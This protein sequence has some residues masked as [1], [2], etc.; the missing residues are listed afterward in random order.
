MVDNIHRR[1]NYLPLIPILSNYR[2]DDFGHDLAAGLVVGVITVPQAIAYAFL[3]GL[4]PQAGLYACLVPMLIY[5]LLGSSRHLVVGPVAV[6]ALMV[7]AMVSEYAPKHSDAYLDITSIVCI[8]AGLFLLLL[9]ISNMGGVVNLLSHPVIVGFINAAAIMIIVSQLR[10]FAGIPGTVGDNPLE[11]GYQLVTSLHLYHPTTLQIAVAS[12]VGLWL[13][14]R[15]SI[16]LLRLVVPS[17]RAE[18]PIRRIGPL[19]IASLATLVVWSLDLATTAGVATIGPVPGGLPGLGWPIFDATLWLQ[20]A[21]GSAMIALVAYVESFSIGTMLATR[22]RTRL[23]ANQELIAL[24]AANI[25]AAVTGAYPVAGSFARSSVNY[26]SGARTPVSSLVCAVIIVLTLLFFTPLFTYMPHA[27]LAAIIIMSISSLIDFRSFR[28]HWRI[29]PEDSITQV[30]TFVCVLA[31]GVEAGLLTGV[32]LSIAFFVRQSSRPHVAVVGRIADTQHFRSTR[33]HPVQTLEQVTAVRVDENLYFANAN[34]IESKL[35]KAVQ[36][37][38]QTKH[39]LLVCS[40]INMVDVSGLEMLTRLNENLKRMRIQFHLSEVKGPV[41]DQLEATEFLAELSG[42]VF[43]T[44][45]QA[46]RDL[47]QVS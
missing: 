32:A 47:S 33:R 26:Q 14:Q 20:L 44:T 5:A 37:R 36:R 12:L 35:L 40:A 30:A 41:M 1:R 22:R 18:H 3:A 25:G 31:F 28:I 39:L 11:R 17:L 45:D 8:E 2:R 4:P 43:F 23:N 24:G 16:P 34:Q 38:P 7:S 29:Y 6:S 10:A 13:V 27:V 42:N 46:I 15:W 9:R 21:P 19:V